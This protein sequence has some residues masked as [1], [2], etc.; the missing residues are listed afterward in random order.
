M[1]TLSAMAENMKKNPKPP[2]THALCAWCQKI[3]SKPGKGGKPIEVPLSETRYTVADFT[4]GGSHGI[5]QDCALKERE[6]F[7][8][9]MKRNPSTAEWNAL[10]ELYKTFHSFDPEGMHVVKVDSDRIPKVLVNI[11]TFE[12][13]TYRSDKFDGQMRSYTHKFKNERP[14]LCA[15]ADGRLYIVGGDY[16]ITERGIEG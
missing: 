13:V 9:Q 16:V 6:R 15:G 8:K 7:K 3:V 2:L 4:E 14:R 1:E 11:G 5:C 10:I 12:E